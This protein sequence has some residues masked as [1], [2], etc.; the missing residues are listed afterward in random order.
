MSHLQNSLQSYKSNND[1][2]NILNKILAPYD[3]HFSDIKELSTRECSNVF[4]KA[5]FLLRLQFHDGGFKELGVCINEINTDKAH[6]SLLD[7]ATLCSSFKNAF[8]DECVQLENY[9]NNEVYQ[10]PE[11]MNLCSNRSFVLNVL[12]N[13]FRGKGVEQADV[14][15]FTNDAK[16]MQAESMTVIKSDDMIESLMAK[17][18]F[19]P[20]SCVQMN[21]ENI[22]FFDGLL[23]LQNHQNHA[24]I[25]AHMPMMVQLTSTNAFSVENIAQSDV[26]DNEQYVTEDVV[27]TTVQDVATIA[28]FDIMVDAAIINNSMLN[29]VISGKVISEQFRE[30]LKA[31]YP[32]INQEHYIV[33]SSPGTNE[34]FKQSIDVFWEMNKQRFDFT[35][36]NQGRVYT[37][38]NMLLGTNGFEPTNI[39]AA[40]KTENYHEN[41]FED[42][43]HINFKHLTTG[44]KKALVK[45][46]DANFRVFLECT[47]FNSRGKNLKGMIY[48][49]SYFKTSNTFEPVFLSKEEFLDQAEQMYAQNKALQTGKTFNLGICNFKRYDGGGRGASNKVRS[50]FVLAF[51]KGKVL[52]DRYDMSQVITNTT[53][54]TPLL[55]LCEE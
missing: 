36:N 45:F 44:H 12:M 43:S 34:L 22:V 49:K 26:E 29:D 7:A 2:C 30:V 55:A 13:A 38:M 24:G 9:L 6:L 37:A 39:F 46:F 51:S 48:N 42:I 11:L 54:H 19:D 3:Y 15:I 5:D 18:M 33:R 10:A 53:A 50:Q 23:Q 28:Q 1:V 4:S 25:I 32:H 27:D 14:V 40:N 41:E 16:C 35:D 52:A 17:Y 8:K 21:N 31:Q 20:S 47:I